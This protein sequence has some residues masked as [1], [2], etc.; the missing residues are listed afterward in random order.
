MTAIAGRAVAAPPTRSSLAS[1]RWQPRARSAVDA[2]LGLQ[3][4]AG[5]RA[6]ASVLSGPVL[7]RKELP[8]TGEGHDLTSPILRGDATLEQTKEG[9]RAI[10]PGARGD[11][12]RRIQE[13]LTTVG[14]SPA[15]GSDSAYGGGTTRA[16]R[17]FQGAV[18]MGA[19]DRDGIVG[20]RTITALDTSANQGTA[21][22][23]PDAESE[24]TI[25][26]DK[27][28]SAQ[29][30]RAFFALASAELDADERAKVAKFGQTHSGK[31]LYLTGL[32][33]EEGPEAGNRA[34]AE[35]RLGAVLGVLSTSHAGP[36]TGEASPDKAKESSRYRFMR[37][38]QIDTKPPTG[39]ASCA[40]GPDGKPP[41]TRVPCDPT[42]RG[43]A[44][45]ARTT[46]AE[47][48]N[49][50]RDALLTSDRS[51]DIAKRAD[52]L[53][54][55]L[56]NTTPDIHDEIRSR[57]G[58]QANA[59]A[60]TV[61]DD[62]RFSCA[63]ECDPGTASG[64]TAVASHGQIS[65]YDK[66]FDDK[67][68][69]PETRGAIVLHEGHHATFT[70]GKDGDQGALRS[71]D[72]AYNYS[73][74]L[75][76]LGPEDAMRNASSF[77]GLVVHVARPA[78]MPLGL[79]ET[80]IFSKYADDM[81]GLPEGQ[82]DS[83]QK[84]LGWIAEWAFTADF[85]VADAYKDGAQARRTGRWPERSGFSQYLLTDFMKRRF[86]LQ[87]PGGRPTDQDLR[88]IAAVNDRVDLMDRAIKQD[89]TIRHVAGAKP[90]WSRDGNH[91]GNEITVSDAMLAADDN[92]R[93]SMLVDALVAATPGISAR[94]AVEYSAL[95]REMHEAGS[96]AGPES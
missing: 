35:Q 38:V 41:E 76:F 39:P 93:T 83:F 34:L 87:M 25:I 31:A 96:R 27:H 80:T 72:V 65:L 26:R 70:G 66:F 3:R 20:K 45:P 92:L 2:V 75:R 11:H 71:T 16:V 9:L 48:A 55:Y 53:V 94:W 21:A 77:H 1:P 61:G 68:T 59:V 42:K 90:R 49:T 37:A 46:A 60:A 22:P 43:L 89:L 36:H 10:K 32:A 5:N 28:T 51:S 54:R 40:A 91:P 62:S 17:D 47:A 29:E 14:H 30:D 6:V 82:R 24:D 79:D 19:A 85:V 74:L 73:R 63:T 78:G 84:S 58:F 69:P 64:H 33:S 23:D 95:L 13:A 12:V 18:G 50:A 44:G 4:T 56:Y 86:G 7:Q 57:V 67:E 52:G 8:T 15:G 88:T 81:T